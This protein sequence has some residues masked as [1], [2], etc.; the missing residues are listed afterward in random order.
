MDDQRPGKAL[1]SRQQRLSRDHNA[2]QKHVINQ[3]REDFFASPRVAEIV[4][5]LLKK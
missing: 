1:V 2:T 4:D 3:I 5:A